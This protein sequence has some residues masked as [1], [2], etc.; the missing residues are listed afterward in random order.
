[1][2]LLLQLLNIQFKARAILSTIVFLFLGPY[3]LIALLQKRTL[4]PLAELVLILFVGIQLFQIIRSL[5]KRSKQNSDLI[6]FCTSN[7]YFWKGTPL[8][9]G[10]LLLWKGAAISQLLDPDIFYYYHPFNCALYIRLVGLLGVSNSVL[11]P[12]S[13]TFSLNKDHCII[14][15]NSDI[16]ATID[17]QKINEIEIHPDHLLITSFPDPIVQI[18]CYEVELNQKQSEQLSNFLQAQ[19]TQGNLAANVQQRNS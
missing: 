19:I 17:S 7:D 10:F 18:K 2:R 9:L 1:M 14:K 4:P 11:R 16:I 8:I 5:V 15:V 6:R 3:L 13:G 12:Y